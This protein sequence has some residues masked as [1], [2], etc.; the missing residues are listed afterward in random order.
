M[1]DERVGMTG[2]VRQDQGSDCGEAEVAQA[3]LCTAEKA[4]ASVGAARMG[5]LNEKDQE[6]QG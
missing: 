3:H 1:D 6:S 5:E 2:D 4:A